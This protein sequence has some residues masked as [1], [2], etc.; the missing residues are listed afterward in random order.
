MDLQEVFRYCTTNRYI[1]ALWEGFEAQ[2]ESFTGFST[3]PFDIDNADQVRRVLHDSD[4]FW[5]H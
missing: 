5:V 2:D 3:N 4:F 1:M